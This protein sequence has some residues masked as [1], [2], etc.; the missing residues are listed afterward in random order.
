M[1]YVEGFGNCIAFM[2]ANNASSNDSGE[3]KK[4]VPGNLLIKSAF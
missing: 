1:L 4:C 2:I 3:K